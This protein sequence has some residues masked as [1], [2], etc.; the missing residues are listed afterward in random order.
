MIATII[1]GAAS[2]VMTSFLKF[3]IDL[4][5]ENKTTIEHLEKN[6]QPFESPFNVNHRHNWSQVFG[7]NKWLWPFPISIGAARPSGN[8]VFWPTQD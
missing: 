3:H 1:T 2:F 7:Q 8:G 4:I 6:G 5:S